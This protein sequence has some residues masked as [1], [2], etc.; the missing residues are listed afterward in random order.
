MKECCENCKY[1]KELIL[2]ATG[3]PDYEH[4]SQCCIVTDTVHQINRS[5]IDRCELFESK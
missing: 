1:M 2:W 4:P 5:K 3:L